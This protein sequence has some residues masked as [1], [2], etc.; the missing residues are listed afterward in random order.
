MRLSGFLFATLA[1]F[2][3]SNFI[4]I[5]ISY[6]AKVNINTA[7]ATELDTIP[8]VGPST[9]AKIITYRE[10]VGPFLVIED[11]MKVSGIKQA[12]FDK[13]KDYITVTDNL[14]G[15]DT[16][17]DTGTT[18]ATSTATTTTSTD[19]SSVSN[20]SHSFITSVHYIQED[21]SEYEEP[22]NLFEVSAGRERL[23]YVNSPVS[24]IAKYKLSKDLIGKSC[25]YSWS[26]GDGLYKGGE[27][28]E[29]LYKY[30]GDYNVVLNGVCDNLLSV[31]RTT[32]KVL[33]PNLQI[34]KMADG[35]VEIFN[36]GKYEVSLYGWKLQAG[37]QTSVFPLDTI[38]SAGKK[39]TLSLDYLTVSANSGEVVLLDA[40]N[41]TI[42]KTGLGS[43]TLNSNPDTIITQADIDKFILEYKK[44]TYI[45]KPKIVSVINPVTSPVVLAMSSD[46]QID[47]ITAPATTVAPTP[48]FWSKFF[49]PIRTIQDA[50]Y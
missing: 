26:F 13:M 46:I 50:F 23:A 27:K 20:S 19:N 29:H 48:G 37:N 33:V 45:Y 1:I 42:A 36:Q 4:S 3:I 15:G 10:T 18:T 47:N 7:N 11:I 43:L 24:F 12:T 38:I 31:S 39:I 9:A 30:T 5:N 21:L 40:L 35:S 49:H 14:P 2:F 41:K 22:T 34:T 32:V 25:L 28:V 6:A 44:L 17:G 16:S 8:E